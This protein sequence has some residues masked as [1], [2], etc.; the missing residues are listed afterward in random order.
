MG[1]VTPF[2]RPLEPDEPIR[3]DDRAEE[4]LRFIRSTMERSTAFTAVSGWALMA[5]GGGALAASLAAARQSHAGWLV[6][7]IVTAAAAIAVS[8]FAIGDKARRERVSLLAGPAQ[9]CLLNFCPPML[10][11][12]LLTA[13]LYHAGQYSVIPGMW[14]LLYGAG[15]AT[16][17]AFTV[18]ILPLMGYC[19]MT[20]GAAALATEVLT[21]AGAGD[22]FMAAGFGG[23][24]LAFGTAILRR[25]GG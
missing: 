11:G 18:R 4:N 12:V 13:V 2:R 8:S 23:L 22:W 1:T 24:H 10:A 6:S 7:W 17:G 15:I 14:L 19:F 20:L 5:T 3:V 9:R 25:Y 21:G 16:G